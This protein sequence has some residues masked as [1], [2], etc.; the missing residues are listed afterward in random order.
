VLALQSGL[1]APSAE[2][3]AA[4]SR[5]VYGI[6]IETSAQFTKAYESKTV[7]NQKAFTQAM[8]GLV[9]NAPAGTESAV[10]V[11]KSALTSSQ[12]AIDSAQKAAR[13]ALA[14]AESNVSAATEKALSAAAAV[15]KKA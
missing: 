6:A 13:K 1:L 4:Y 11:L 2:R 5:H 15:S 9:K 3:V 14:L 12:N 8:D 7:E 10:A